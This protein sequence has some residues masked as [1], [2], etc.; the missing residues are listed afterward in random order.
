MSPT[1]VVNCFESLAV[2][3]HRE[4]IQPG[5]TVAEVWFEDTCLLCVVIMFK[6]V[7]RLIACMLASP[8]T[9]YFSV[10]VLGLIFLCF[11]SKNTFS[12]MRTQQKVQSESSS[13]RPV[14][15]R[16]DAFWK[17]K[18]AFWTPKKGLRTLSKEGLTGHKQKRNIS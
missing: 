11:C 15:T 12:E 9:L 6:D 1:F 10:F 4:P 3:L 18:D 14:R 17:Q 8:K 16:K 5:E 7:Q 2:H 13:G